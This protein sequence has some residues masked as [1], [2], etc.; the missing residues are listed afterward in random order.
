MDP[1]NFSLR[2]RI[3]YGR[4]SVQRV[5]AL[6]RELR[7]KRALIVTD[8]GVAASGALDQ[9]L[10]SLKES[11][12]KAEV[13]DEVEPNPTVQIVDRGATRY[14]DTAC[15]GIVAVG[16]G[17]ALDTGKSVAVLAT[18]PGIA[19]DYLGSGKVTRPA[20][21]IIC[22][23][24]TSGTAAE[25]TDVAVL[26]D[27]TKKLK[28]GLRSVYVAPTIALL[29]PYLTVTLPPGPTR[30]S[31]LDAL[32]HAVEAYISLNSWPVTDALALK[33]IELIGRHLRTATHQGQ[34]IEARDGMLTASLLAGMAFHN[35]MLCLV[36]AITG[37]LGGMYNLPHGA[38][39]AIVLPHAM[40]FLL[41]GAVPKYRD[42][43]SALGE[44]VN[45]LSE[46]EAAERA[47]EA[48]KLLADDVG[49]TQGLSA[50][51]VRD[52]DLPQIA[53]TIAGSYM[54]PLSPRQ[55]AAAEILEVC[56]EAM[57]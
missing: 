26:S 20:A 36:H 4:H 15:S 48:V 30:E 27:R 56:R 32:T 35:T 33:S 45:G 8:S 43:A 22:L 16:G 40:R 57:G 23:P 31:G 46:R 1:I 52:Q 13:F 47:V 54:I 18:N 9:V 28:A 2:T 44:C 51:G 6:A 12:V 34:D 38:A 29:D 14:A 37:P 42:I 24:T 53:E 39:N 21:P 11:R 41:P 3:V 5:G 10:Q 25:V 7:I 49:L 19:S 50:Y 55:A 17:S